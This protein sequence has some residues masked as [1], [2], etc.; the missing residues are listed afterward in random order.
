MESL[1][2]FICTYI[3]CSDYM[4]TV[5]YDQL[6]DQDKERY[7]LFDKCL[8]KNLHFNDHTFNLDDDVTG[9]TGTLR[10]DDSANGSDCESDFRSF[11]K[12]SQHIIHINARSLRNKLTDMRILTK[13]T[14]ASVIAV[15]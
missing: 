13:K 7:V 5:D 10:T 11:K 9:A 12:R 4:T 14:N 2:P 15:S 3:K 6:V 1:L 8:S